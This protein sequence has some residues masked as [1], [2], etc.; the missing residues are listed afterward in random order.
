MKKLVDGR[1]FVTAKLGGEPYGLA[2]SDDGATLYVTL[3]TDDAV[4]A[5]DTYDFAVR[6]RVAVPP[7]PRS[8]VLDRDRLLVGHVAES[9]LTVL[10][11]NT[12]ETLPRVPL[13]AL[14]GARPAQAWAMVPLGDELFILHSGA[15]TG[16]DSARSATS[17]YGSTKAPVKT[18][19]TLL[20]PRGLTT[21]VAE[22]KLRQSAARLVRGR[23]SDAGRR[24]GGVCGSRKNQRFRRWRPDAD[25]PRGLPHGARDGLGRAAALRVLVARARRARVRGEVQ[26]PLYPRPATSPEQLGNGRA[27]AILHGEAADAPSRGSGPDLGDRAR[28]APLSRGG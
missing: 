20:N 11:P 8:I 9:A 17:Y 6:W 13:S 15:Q 1:D 27:P 14:P 18:I 19:G 3:A 16:E 24:G 26:R 25:D 10:D 12:G 22:P 4:V 28:P 21:L 2:R 23:A 7:R 5:L